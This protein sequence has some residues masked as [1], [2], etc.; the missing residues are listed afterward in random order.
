MK[1]QHHSLRALR[2]MNGRRPKLGNKLWLSPPGEIARA[3]VTFDYQILIK[4]IESH[5]HCNLSKT[6]VE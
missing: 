4:R 6:R 3:N 5:A 1:T 2:L